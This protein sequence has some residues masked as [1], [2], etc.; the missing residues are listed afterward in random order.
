MNSY[1]KK[2]YVIYISLI[3]VDFAFPLPIFAASFDCSK[4]GS[5]VEK[6]ICTD[7]SLSTLDEELSTAYKLAIDDPNRSI[8][9]RQD[10]KKWLIERNSCAD[11][12]CIRSAYLYRIQTLHLNQNISG[13]Q[14]TAHPKTEH[15]EKIEEHGMAGKGYPPYPEVWDWVAPEYAGSEMAIYLWTLSN[16]DI[17]VNYS[18][19]NFPHDNHTFTFF[20]RYTF[21]K[22]ENALGAYR[23]SEEKATLHFNDGKSLQAL[24]CL[25][26]RSGG[27]YNR[28]DGS[29]AIRNEVNNELVLRKSLLYLFDKPQHFLTHRKCLDGKE[30]DYWVDSVFPRFLPLADGTFL[31]IDPHGLIVRFDQNLNS[32]SKLINSRLFWMDNLDLEKFLAKYGDRAIENKN[33]KELHIDLHRLILDRV[34][35]S[36]N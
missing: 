4:A 28:L 27:C 14:I 17:L 19:L 1:Y 34:N 2:I 30:F 23:P 25:G 35:N 15:F 16:G 20:N 21:N 5:Q 11:S 26:C 33:L 3:L 7:S 13:R 18:N 31:L 29:M 10:Q 12:S 6:L 8:S 9:V 36:K 32:R 24:G 22:V